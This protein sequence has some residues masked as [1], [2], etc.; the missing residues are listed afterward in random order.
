MPYGATVVIH[1]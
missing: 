1:S